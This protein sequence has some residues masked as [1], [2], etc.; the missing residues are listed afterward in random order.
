MIKF[1][2]VHMP[3]KDKKHRPAVFFAFIS[4]VLDWLKIQIFRLKFYNFINNSVVY[5]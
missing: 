3:L 5:Y 2:L 1:L 4:I